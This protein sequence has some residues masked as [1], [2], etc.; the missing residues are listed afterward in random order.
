MHIIW[1]LSISSSL[2]FQH[3]PLADDSS[4]QAWAFISVTSIEK[5]RA[6]WPTHS[7]LKNSPTG[8]LRNVSLEQALNQL[9]E[10]CTPAFPHIFPFYHIIPLFLSIFHLFLSSSQL[11]FTK[12]FNF[13]WDVY[14][15]CF[16]KLSGWLLSLLDE[17]KS[18]SVRSELSMAL[19][20]LVELTLRP[21]NT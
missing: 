4:G 10:I 11:F 13:H 1:I 6:G 19:A 20:N 14:I 17:L 5:S 21:W 2:Y 3:E 7:I 12:L 15:R 8:L 16:L 9:W 18:K